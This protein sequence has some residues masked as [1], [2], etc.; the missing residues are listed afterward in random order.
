MS[1]FVLTAQLQLQ[2]PN[3]VAQVVRQIQSQLNNVNVNLNIQNAARTQRQLQQITTQTQAAGTAADRMGRAFALSVRRFA[4]FSIATRAVGLFTSTLSK[5]VQTAIDFERELVKISQVTGESISKLKGLTNTIGELS[6]SLGVSS[7][8][9]I[10][11][12]RILSQAGFKAN[13]LDI[14][15]KTLAKTELAPTFDDITQTAEGAIAI[16]NQFGQGAEALERQ[17]GA[18][19][20][21]AGKFAVEAGDLIDVVRRAGGVFKASGG[22]LNELI[23]LFTSVRATTRE[24]AESIGTGLRTI[25]TRIQRPKTIEFLKQFGVE[26]VDLEGKFVGP[27]EAVRRLSAALAGLEE[28]DLTFIRIAEELGGFRQI[29][30]VLPLLQQF[31]VAQNA[32]NVANKAGN[33]LTEDAAKAQQALAVRIMKVKEEFLALVRGITETKTFQIMANTA[34]SLAEALIKIGEAIK[35]LLPLLTALAAVNFARGIGTFAGGLMRGM[36][37]GR[38][39]NKGGKVHHFARGGMVPGTGNSDTVPAMLQPGEFVIKKSSVNKLGASNLAAMNENKY[40]LGGRVGAIALNPIDGTSK[41]SGQV[42]IRD[43]YSKLS[44][45]NQLKGGISGNLKLFNKD[46]SFTNLAKNRRESPDGLSFSQRIERVI[47]R[48][49]FNGGKQQKFTTIGAAFPSTKNSETTIEQD[50]KGNITRS[51]EN[52]IPLAASALASSIGVSTATGSINKN[53]IKSIG[54]EDATGKIFEAAVSSLGAPFD[55]NA[56]KEDRDAFDFPFGIGANLSQFKPFSQLLDIP[57]DAKKTLDPSKLNDIATRKTA[58]TLAEQVNTN[59]AFQQLKQRLISQENS[60][61]GKS[62]FS[63]PRGPR[64]K[65]AGGIIQKFAEGGE[66]IIQK[67][68]QSTGM[69]IF[70]SDMIAGGTNIKNA[71]LQSLL[72]SGKP[73]SVISGPAGSGKTTFAT[74]RFG[75]NFV[76]SPQDLEKY[77]RFVVLSGAGVTKTGGFSLETDKLLRGAKDITVLSPDEKRLMQQRQGRLDAATSGA[78]PDQRSV[79]ALKGTL[80]APTSANL[81]LLKRYRNVQILQKYADG[82]GVGTDTV[83]ALLTPGEFVVNK[84]SA[85]AI[86][87]GSLNR[88]N[89]VGKYAKGGVVQGFNTGTTGTGVKSSGGLSFPGFDSKPLSM[90]QKAILDITTT[91]STGSQIANKVNSKWKMIDN[92]VPALA[93]ALDRY[94][95]RLG[96]TDK[97]AIYL[98]EAYAN[99]VSKMVKEGA[100]TDEMTARL[101]DYIHSLQAATKAHNRTATQTTAPSSSTQASSGFSTMT[102]T[103]GATAAGNSAQVINQNTTSIQNN[104]TAQDRAA[105]SALGIVA[106]NKLFAV[107]MAS[108]L[109]QGFLPAINENSGALSILTQSLLGFL[110]IVTSVGFGLQA[111]GISLSQAGIAAM[112]DSTIAAFQNLNFKA[113]AGAVTSFFTQTA[114]TTTN[115]TATVA[116]TA[117]INSNTAAQLTAGQKLAGGF[118]AALIGIGLVTAGF[119]LFFG[120]LKE[121][122]RIDKERAIKAGDA[123][124][125][126]KAAE[127]EAASG[128]RQLFSTVGA[129]IGGTVAAAAALYSG[130]GIPAV[131]AAGAA[132]A[133]AGGAAGLGVAELF[134][135]TEQAALAAKLQAETAARMS[136]MN[137]ILEKSSKTAAESL[138]KLEK[139]A[140]TARDALDSVSEGTAAAVALVESAKATEGAAIAAAN[141]RWFGRDAAVARARSEGAERTGETRKKAEEQLRIIQPMLN[142]QMRTTAFE[143]GDF[144]DFIS[145]LSESEVALLNLTENGIQDAYKQFVSISNEI[146]RARKQFEA[147]NLGLRSVTAS[148]DAA[149]MRMTNSMNSFDLAVVPGVGALNTLQASLTAAGQNISQAEFESALAEVGGILKKFGADAKQLSGFKDLARGVATV[150]REFPSIFEDIKAKIKAD[151]FRGLSPEAIGQEFKK[152][153]AQSLDKANIGDAAKQRII[154]AMGD[155]KISENDMRA[156]LAGDLSSLEKYFG[157]AAEE[158]AKNI[159][160][161]GEK[162]VTANQELI[163]ATQERIESERNF[164][165]AQ[166]EA[167]NVMMEAREIQAKYG[168]APVSIQERRGAILGRAN[169]GAASMGLAGMRTGSVAELRRRNMQILGGFAGIEARRGQPGSEMG[170]KGAE[171]Q[172]MQQNLIQAQ[173]DQVQTIRDLIKLEEEELKILQEKNK[174]EKDS[175]ESLITG[176]IEKFFEQQAA[177]GAQASIAAGNMEAANMFGAK[178]VADAFKDLQRQMDAGVQSLF[179][180]QLGGA[181]GLL[182]SAAGAALAGRGV[183]DPRMAQRLAQTT[184][185]EEEFKARIR[186]LSDVLG[187]AAITGMAMAEMQVQTAQ[188]KVEKAEIN[189][190]NLGTGGAPVQAR[191]TGG[192][193]YANR[194][195]FVPRG[196]DTV[197]AMLTPGEFVVRREAVN[198]G[199]NLQMLKAINGGSEPS[200]LARGGKVGYYNTGGRVS[201]SS[202]NPNIGI[203]PT[204]ISNLSGVFDKFINGFN[205]SIKNLRDTKLQVKLDSVNVNVN[206]T[207]T[208]MLT[209]ISNEARSKIIDEV[210]QKLKSE[211]GV[212]SDGKIGENKSLLPRPGG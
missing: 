172:G 82:G 113:I 189:I 90:L 198:R 123:E 28:G 105:R 49:A 112:I 72:G 197:P 30:K 55:S 168:G 121:Q 115:T 167:I 98:T 16:F 21:V 157:D 11:V 130:V 158:V 71:L 142:R 87:Y 114:A 179:G 200:T 22:E 170:A 192:L 137:K 193:I 100:T 203:D 62:Q 41:G 201:G 68:V 125:A 154:D 31:S 206:F 116:Q 35:P 33:S 76:L 118:Q 196:T 166:K 186:D 119:N 58:N 59:N 29:G 140:I 149:A 10:G 109:I 190:A 128:V 2:A 85:Q 156:I 97:Q 210:V 64:L 45:N 202:R 165:A 133:A 57:T 183:T 174:L 129:A 143:G 19:N 86:G 194:G 51:Y 47:S 9:L 208:S 173:K 1:R 163:K 36:Q 135:Y 44:T 60:K 48:I 162:W 25:F 7:T 89:K 188:M 101:A 70:D 50:I 99:L 27:F 23:A 6:T 153:V 175:L 134:G 124:A 141:R 204:I 65:N 40:A 24:S 14:A 107:S 38:T 212:R 199:N 160:E 145:S 63:K 77:A 126:G 144:D 80:K 8:S 132:G 43:I 117:A 122:A 207:G 78:I 91:F 37:S 61:E 181:G 209:Q 54:I 161:F 171:L 152:L 150:Q 18:I 96:L 39:Y 138:D 184:A 13:E 110:T 15:L 120:Y 205:E 34:L 139:G 147:L 136:N 131:G 127:A 52:I 187:E 182:E 66:A 151:E 146:E 84:K 159:K 164:V 191:A 53:L 111:F 32:L 108:S 5:A 56:S 103:M 75:R 3:N 81:D 26:L 79:G 74:S 20:A 88:M 12:S 94:I 46:G 4:A 177:L 180:R 185:E 148:A 93:N 102:G 106:G 95:S 155:V 92:S 176:D 169:A 211:Y 67:G 178:A 17:L 104:S 42:T 73:Y 83:P 69:G 195:M